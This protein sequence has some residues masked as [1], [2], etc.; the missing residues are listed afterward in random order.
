[1]ERG[2]NSRGG[3]TG[4][5]PKE[6]GREVHVHLSVPLHERSFAFGAHVLAVEVRVCREVLQ[7]EGTSGT[8]PIWFPLY[9]NADQGLCRQV[10]I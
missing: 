1:M 10:G 7:T 8:V 6:S 5:A 9:R 4:N 3:R 2:E